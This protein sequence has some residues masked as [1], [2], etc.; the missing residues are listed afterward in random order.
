MCFDNYQVK[1][2]EEKY[3]HTMMVGNKTTIIGGGLV[4]FMSA[5]KPSEENPGEKKGEMSQNNAI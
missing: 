5:M 2:E 3:V 1:S 4:Y